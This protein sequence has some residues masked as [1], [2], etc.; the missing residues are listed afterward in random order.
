MYEV[1]YSGAFVDRY[2]S[3]KDGR[4]FWLF[5]AADYYGLLQHPSPVALCLYC[6][7]TVC[8]HECEPPFQQDGFGKSP[9]S[10]GEYLLDQSSKWASRQVV[11]EGRA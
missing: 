4:L 5:T 8:T 3:A 10:P 7:C 11:E 9:L 6:A 2:S 1:L